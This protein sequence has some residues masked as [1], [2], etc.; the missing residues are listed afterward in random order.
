[1]KKIVCVMLVLVTIGTVIGC[2]PNLKISFESLISP[3]K[4]VQVLWIDPDPS[5]AK[6][7][8]VAI[9]FGNNDPHAN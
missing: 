3:Q 8:I 5:Q 7:L 1:M 4:G 2:A 9:P 6:K